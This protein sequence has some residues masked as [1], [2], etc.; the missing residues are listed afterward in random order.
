VSAI[1]VAGITVRYGDVLALDNASISVGDSRVTGLVG[2][3]GSGK[4][5]LFK[6]I[7]G[8][9]TPESGTVLVRGMTPAAARRAGVLAYMP[10]NEGVD[11]DFPVSVGDVVMMGRYGSQ[12]FTRRVRAIDR[13]AVAEALARVELDTASSRQIGELS[14][15]QRKRVFIARA[16]AQGATTLLLDEPFAGVDRR[17]EATITALLR[18]LSAGGASILVS[19]HNLDSLTALCDE[20]FLWNRRTIAHGTPDAVL[21]THNLARAFG[22]TRGD[23]R[24]DT[25][26]TTSDEATR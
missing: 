23:A 14:G 21:T 16:I 5:T 19:T 20:V 4:S 7:L 26:G 15:G 6:S 9:L 2:V 24:G 8:L 13:T 25:Q 17:S 3:N 18:S 10:Q 1:D 11:W 12:G 22:D